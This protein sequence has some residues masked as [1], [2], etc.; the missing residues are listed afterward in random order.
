MVVCH[1]TR[2]ERA[3]APERVLKIVSWGAERLVQIGGNLAK[4][5]FIVQRCAFFILAKHVET[6]KLDD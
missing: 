2:T 4:L 5:D 6:E 1:S 3:V